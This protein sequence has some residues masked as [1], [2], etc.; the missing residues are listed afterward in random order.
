M[1]N[2]KVVDYP[3]NVRGFILPFLRENTEHKVLST[4]SLFY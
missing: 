1:Q 3:R 4:Q 2:T